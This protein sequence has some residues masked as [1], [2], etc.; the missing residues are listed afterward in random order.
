MSIADA[1]LGHSGEETL[2]SRANWI[3]ISKEALNHQFDP[4]IKGGQDSF[5]SP[6]FLQTKDFNSHG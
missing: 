3:E 6:D 2:I 4:C 1:D 5:T